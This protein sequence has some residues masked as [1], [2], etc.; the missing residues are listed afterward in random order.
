MENYF[1][2]Q[3]DH[4]FRN[5]EV[6]IY[7]FDVESMDL[8]KDLRHYRS[9][10]EAILE[11]SKEA[12]VFC[13]IHKMDL[14]PEEQRDEAFRRKEQELQGE[15]SAPASRRAGLSRARRAL[16]AAQDHV[17]CHEHL[18]RDAVQGMVR[19]GVLA[20]SQRAHSGAALAQL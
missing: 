6:L 7:V 20:H 14:V 15:R 16:V 9:S 17:L 1:A 8:E 4:I 18:G 5:V 11:N 19:H 13:L 3:R 10:L 2:S 12:K